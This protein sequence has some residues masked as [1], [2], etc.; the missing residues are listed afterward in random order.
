MHPLEPLKTYLHPWKPFGAVMLLAG[1]LL[2]AGFS[3]GYVGSTSGVNFNGALWGYYAILGLVLAVL[4]AGLWFVARRDV[5][6]QARLDR[7]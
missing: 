3:A 7:A 1:G 4:G 2:M 5:S 6:L